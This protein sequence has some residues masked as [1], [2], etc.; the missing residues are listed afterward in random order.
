MND[1][2][3]KLVMFTGEL[4][5]HLHEDTDDAFLGIAGAG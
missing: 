2:Q 4:V 3:I 5:W 1:Y